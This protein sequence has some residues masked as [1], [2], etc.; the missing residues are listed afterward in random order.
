MHKKHT[1]LIGK[2]VRSI[3]KLRG[4][5]TALPGLVVEKLDKNFVGSMLESLPQGVV[6]VSGTNG[7]T[8]TTKIISEVLESC[9]LRVFT[10][11]TGSNFVRGI[12]A[13]IIGEVGKSGRLPHDI[14]VLELDEAHAVQFICHAPVHH[15][16]LLNVMRDQLDRFGEIDYT[17]R[18][19]EKV[20]ASAQKNVVLNRDDP[21]ITSLSAVVPKGAITTYFGAAPSLHGVFLNDDELY[22]SPSEQPLPPAD[23]HAASVELAA[24]SETDASF[25]VSGQIYQTPLKVRGVYNFLNAAGAL[26]LCKAVLGTQVS[27]KQLVDALANIQPA[28]GRGETLTIMGRQVE[29]ILVKNPAGFR[30]AL[31]SFVPADTGVMIAINDN[32]ADGRDMSWLWDVDFSSLKN[33]GVHT[34]TGIRAYDMALRLQYDEVPVRDVEPDLKN[35]LESF[36]NDSNADK[37]RIFCTYTSMLKLRRL[38]RKYTKLEIMG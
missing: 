35:A 37:Q 8:T 33:G 24:F 19:L 12:A 6:V 3:A 10:N 32:Y 13:A 4:G 9:G 29:L 34:V 31:A 1:I 17:A 23:L 21:R 38:L 11:K 7:K 18:L 14:A 2:A 28:F 16:L 30:L 5:G 25:K 22:Q 36:L 27:D 20:A 15:A 26:A